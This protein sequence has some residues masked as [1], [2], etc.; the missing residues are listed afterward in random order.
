M[1][2]NKEVQ[3][4]QHKIAAAIAKA[5]HQLQFTW[6][7]FM[8]RKFAR[9]GKKGQVT[10]LIMILAMGTLSS[11]WSFKGLYH[12]HTPSVSKPGPIRHPVIIDYSPSSTVKPMISR[13]EM[14]QLQRYRLIMDS[15]ARSPSGRYQYDSIMAAHP[16]MMDT[17]RD[18]EQ[19]YL[20]QHASHNNP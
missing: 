3:G 10:A 5:L 17:I 11:L 2:T 20:E 18:I 8:N 6:A 19:L 1:K 12:D 14:A 7:A 9:L 4:G 16:G 15:L 13:E